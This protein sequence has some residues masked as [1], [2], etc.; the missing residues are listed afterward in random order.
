MTT[1]LVTMGLLIGF[2][3]TVH[4]MSSMIPIFL[5]PIAVVDSIHILSEFAEIHKP[6]A[7]VK[8]SIRHVV[9]NLFQPMLFTSITS[10]VGFASLAFTPIPP[11]QVFGLF[12]AFGIG[13]A[14]LLTIIFIPAYI[15]VLSPASI[16]KLAQKHA[17]NESA[18]DLRG[19]LNIFHALSGKYAK[20]AISAALVISVF[21]FLG[22][23]HIEINDNPARW[24]KEDHRTRVADKV[25]NEHFAGTYD[26]Y[27]VLKKDSSAQELAFDENLQSLAENNPAVKNLLSDAPESFRDFSE[28]ISWYVQ[29]SYDAWFEASEDADI[30]AFKSVLMLVEKPQTNSKYL[31]S[32]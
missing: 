30:D 8:D 14:F 13:L 9:E 7:R 24:L 10:A 12:V 25:L 31:A 4:I 19:P 17:S 26:A 11:V 29:A 16:E 21:S 15:A 20:P 18:L 1:V 23:K 22:S 32:P 27:L 28:K 3:F 2:G 5:M 6:G